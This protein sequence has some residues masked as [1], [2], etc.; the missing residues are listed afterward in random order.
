MPAVT[1][2]VTPDPLDREIKRIAPKIESITG[3]VL[4]NVLD[5]DKRVPLIEEAFQRWVE[6]NAVSGG[7]EI[8]ETVAD[9]DLLSSMSAGSYA[10]T[11]RPL[12]AQQ[13]GLHPWPL[14]ASLLAGIMYF[15][16]GGQPQA[17]VP[18]V[19]APT[20]DWD[21]AADVM[22][23]RGGVPGVTKWPDIYRPP[24][25]GGQMPV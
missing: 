25:V 5:A 20:I 7:Q 14:L 16:S 24:W 21:R 8:L 1:N 15:D 19:G 4:A 10:E 6:Y 23:A 12:S 18:K 17:G 11:R 13:R 9:F 2:P 22:E 3:L